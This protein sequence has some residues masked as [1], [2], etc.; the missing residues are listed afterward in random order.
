MK[1]KIV[2]LILGIITS[3]SS[4][5]KSIE[6]TEA[7]KNETSGKYLVRPGEVIEVY[8]ENNNLYLKW[9]GAE[10]LKPVITSEN[11][12][13]VADMYKKLQFVQHPQTKQRFLSIIDGKES[14]TITYDYKR[15]P[16]T[17]KLPSEHLSDGNFEKAL[18]G[19]LEIQKENP[20]S[21]YIKERRLNS[22]GYDYIRDKKYEDTIAVLAINKILYPDSDNV[23]DSLAYAYLVNNDSLQAF[24][25][26]KKAFDLN[27][28][29]NS[30]KRYIEAYSKKE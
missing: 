13:F 25:N 29:N 28:R 18:E 22:L 10:K 9:R 24:T 3:L 12:F 17:Y 16:K 23:Y 6:Y 8:Y 20:K 26:Y 21:D 11:E 4:C 14:T 2:M 7:F 15:L 1:S 19:F 30:A 27:S 5:S